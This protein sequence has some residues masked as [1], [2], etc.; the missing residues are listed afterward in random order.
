[1]E[2][3]APSMWDFLNPMDD[4][5][6][7]QVYPFRV[8]FWVAGFLGGVALLMTVSGI[9]GVMS[10][11][12]SQ[13]TKEIGI[14]VALGATGWD[15]VRTVVRQ[16]ARLSAIGTAMGVGLALMVAPDIRAR[17]RVDPAI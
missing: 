7:L 8:V 1:M 3:V 12:V 17:D 14:R 5:A 4:V 6:A 2:Q 15:V 16:S 9:Y 10:Y 13:R 11:L